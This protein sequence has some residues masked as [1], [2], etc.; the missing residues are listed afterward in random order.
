MRLRDT[1]PYAVLLAALAATV[2][3]A[4]WAHARAV[5][6]ATA[7]FNR[8]VNRKVRDLDV[9]MRHYEDYLRGFAGL[10]AASSEVTQK[11]WESYTRSLNLTPESNV[12]SAFGYSPVIEAP[13]LPAHVTAVRRLSPGYR[14]LPEPGA[15]RARYAPVTLVQ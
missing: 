9:N 6:D 7:R 1:L 11:E 8:L 2:A 4:W 5:D 10:F 3:V 12:L 13:A 14:I 15:D